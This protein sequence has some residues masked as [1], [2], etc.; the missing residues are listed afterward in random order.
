LVFKNYFA[1]ALALCCLASTADAAGI[2]LLNSDPNLAGAIWYPCLGESKNVAL[3]KL[4]LSDDIALTGVKDCPTASAQ[5]PLIIFSHGRS[6]WFGG[7]NDT[8]EAL[9]DAGF[10]VAAITHPGDNGNDTSQSETLSGWASRPADIVRLIDFV[11]KDWKDR[12]AIDPSRIGLFGFSKGAFTGLVLAG[13]TLDFQRTAS[14][15]TDNTRFCA[16]VRGG[17]VPQNLPSDIRIRAAVLAD[18]AP[19]TAFTKDTLSSIHVPL[20]VW[21][22]ELGAKD[23]GV[24]PE[25]VARVFSALPGQPEVHIV[26]AGHFAFLP[27]CSPRFAASQP[28]FCTDPAGFDRAAFHR[29]FNASVVR[30]FRDHLAG[31]G[32][33]R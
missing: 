33:V 19:T 1:C 16:Q 8:A 30:F 4:A 24:A 5:L 9:A 23:R 10:V 29:D 21:R 7:H 3:G 27:P 15:C 13:A 28:R 14:Y 12:D 26:P 17:D 31:D 22:S 2:Q 32:V 11:L 25:G 18:P 6:G 20:Q